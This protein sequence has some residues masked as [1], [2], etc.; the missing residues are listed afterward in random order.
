[1][2]TKIIDGGLLS[3]PREQPVFVG[4]DPSLTGYAL[5]AISGDAQTYA[6]WVYKSGHR[7]VDRLIDISIWTSMILGT[8]ADH[9]RRPIQDV[10]I[11]DT[12][13]MSHAAV[14]LGELHGQVRVA[15]YH[16]LPHSAGKY[17]LKVPPTT[18][19]KYVTGKG[20]ARKNEVMLGVYKNWGVEFADDNA[21]DSYALARISSGSASNAVQRETLAKLSD[22]KFRDGIF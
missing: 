14:A 8:I 11:E 20:N 22:P 10:A 17:P 3:D 2:S 13:V 6:S 4:I 21:A 15:L 9:G 19:K 7:G 1:M 12:V 18:V 16:A 5:T